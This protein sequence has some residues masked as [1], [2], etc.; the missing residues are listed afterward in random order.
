[1]TVTNR[2]TVRGAAHNANLSKIAACRIVAV[3]LGVA[4]L[5]AGALLALADRRSAYSA[6]VGGLIGALP[7]FYL[8][9]RVFAPA[10]SVSPQRLVQAF[11][12]GS[13]VKILLSAALFVIA[14]IALDVRAGVVL[15]T[16]AATILVL[17]LGLLL[18][19][20]RR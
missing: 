7:N 3:Q 9:A 1:M 6:L 13:A 15:G 16:Y 19:E 17:W 20:P 10:A 14:F 12:A 8:A 5:I 4:L 2:E 11:Y 18:P